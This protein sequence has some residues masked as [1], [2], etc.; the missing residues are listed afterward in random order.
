MSEPG[1]LNNVRTCDPVTAEELWAWNRQYYDDIRP[2]LPSTSVSK[3]VTSL[4]FT[5]CWS[6][7]VN[8]SGRDRTVSKPAASYAQ[9]EPGP[10][11]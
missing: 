5:P 1:S 7:V 8:M 4:P 10:P 3:L 9:V 2:T 6:S 11:T